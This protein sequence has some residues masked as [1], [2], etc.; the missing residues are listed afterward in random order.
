M[1]NGSTLFLPTLHQLN[2]RRMCTGVLPDTGGDCDLSQSAMRLRGG[3]FISFVLV[4][5]VCL[6][7]DII[8]FFSATA[9][10]L[11]RVEAFAAHCCVCFL[12]RK[13]KKRYQ[14][15]FEQGAFILLTAVLVGH[16]KFNF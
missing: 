9:G 12:G 13:K 11:W 5:S 16:N 6:P 15:F 4:S 14:M 2:K 8:L 3:D 7:P 10:D 1:S